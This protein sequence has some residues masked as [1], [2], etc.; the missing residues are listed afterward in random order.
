MKNTLDDATLSVATRAFLRDALASLD[1]ARTAAEA[2][3][4]RPDR[5]LGQIERAEDGVVAAFEA[6]SPARR[7]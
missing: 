6:A 1:R 5:L 2:R 3:Q 7:R 4:R